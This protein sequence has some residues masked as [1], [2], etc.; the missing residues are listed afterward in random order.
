[1]RK[2]TFIIIFSGLYSCI[3]AQK[4]KSYEISSPDNKIK[5]IITTGSKLHWSLQQNNQPVILP[6][7]V[8]LQLENENIGDNASIISSPKEKVSRSYDAV[9]YHKKTV[10]DEYNQLTLNLKGNSGIIFRAYND[11]ALTGS[12]RKK[13]A[14]SSSTAKKQILTSL[15]IRK[16]GILYNGITAMEKISIR[17]S[18]HCTMKQTCLPFQKIPLPFFRYYLL[19]V[20]IKKWPYWRPT[21]KI[22][23]VCTLT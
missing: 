11:A 14:G 16:P 3:Y 22:T 13:M 15:R 4:N 20:I 7:S 10:K 6:S 1:M 17:H 12:S 23:R 18:K 21:S 19:P 9:N 2:I 8:S 5:I